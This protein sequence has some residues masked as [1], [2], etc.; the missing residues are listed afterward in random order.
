MNW[1]GNY[2]YSAERWH[3]PTTLEQV[4]ELVTQCTQLRAVG[5]RHSFNGIA[6]CTQDMISLQDCDRVLA[7]DRER[8]TVTVEAGIRYGQLARYLEST[9]YALHNLA[10]LPHISVAGACATATHGSGDGN[11]NLATAVSAL[12]IV[13]ADGRCVT[14]SRAQD[15]DRFPGAVVGLGALGVVTKL[16]LDIV[17]AFTLRQ[18]VYENLPMAHLED[19]FDEIMASAYSVSLFTDW[20][21][22][23]F[24]Q[25][26]RKSVLPE[27]AKFHENPG[28]FGAT[29]ATE[30]RHP[31]A[32][33]PVENCT[34]QM[35]APGPWHERLPHFR[36]DYLASAGEELQSEYLVPRRFAC[37]ALRALSGIRGRIA[38]LLQISEIRTVAADDL[39]MST[40][41]REASVAL[42]FTWLKE[43]PAVQALLPEIEAILA[44]FEARPH[45]GKLFTTPAERL[46]S[47]YPK[48]P[49]FRNLVRSFDPHGKF[50]NAYLETFL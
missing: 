48:L 27:D 29:P 1:A 7:L 50:R 22:D 23:V 13:T 39:W 37:A 19:R 38:P 15:S 9:G 31:L 24:N 6:D 34:A 18:D 41:Y 17:P 43:W 32:G 25:W 40:C 3:F 33:L 11:G 5:T 12:E 20:R 14:L 47:L 44:P 46:Q 35:G 21:T 30:P 8:S 42:H 10:S 2:L 45:W 36:M 16:T 49:E 4:P 28:R 26:W